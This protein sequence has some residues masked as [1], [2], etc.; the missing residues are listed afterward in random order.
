LL[1]VTDSLIAN[2]VGA[3]LLFAASFGQRFVLP[4]DAHA[5]RLAALSAEER[6]FAARAPNSGTATHKQQQQQQ[7]QHATVEDAPVESFE[8]AVDVA[9]ERDSVAAAFERVTAA[10]ERPA[11]KRA[12][13]GGDEL[14]LVV[15]GSNKPKAH[16]SAASAA[17][18]ASPSLAL[19]LYE[20]L[21][22]EKPEWHAPWKLMRV[23]SGHTGWV[24]C[25]AVDAS[26]EWFA[27]GSAD[28]MI[29]VWDLA[30]GKL[31]VSLTGHINTVRGLAISERHPYLF[32]VGDDKMVKSWDLETNQVTRQYHGHLSGVYCC[33]LHPTLDLLFTGSRDS[34]V[35]VWDMRTRAAVFVLGGH[36]DTVWSVA[37]Q[38]A[39]PQLISGSADCTVRLW[40]LTT[41]K[42]MG[43]LTHHKKQIRSVILHPTEYTFAT[44]AADN[45]KKWMCPEARFMLNFT[46][47]NAIVN[48]IAT[49]GSV[50][51]SGA[52]NGSMKFWDWKT[53]HCYQ[54][55]GTIAQPGSL[56]AEAGI[57]ASAFDRTGTRLITCE[58]DKTI[59]FW[60]EDDTATEHSHPIADDW[61]IAVKQ[62]VKI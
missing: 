28:R 13:T 26:N 38:A 16:A 42:T 24:R 32:S 33:A 49:N 11:A 53:G 15:A 57:F 59:K 62:A 36:R 40:D 34:T 17:S 61:R 51:F 45:I 58:A 7:Q 60:R 14:A 20:R 55:S 6:A 30:S 41:G 19:S 48:T 46:G 9:R 50:L 52:D 56:S 18:A 43:Q 3:Q 44:G 5:L 8:T 23:V 4:T 21:E 12:R 27:T 39:E 2:R 22:S 29:K 31:K 10:V 25:I 37:A 47:H 35:R 54:D 1:Q